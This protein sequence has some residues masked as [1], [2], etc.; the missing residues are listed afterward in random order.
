MLAPPRGA[1][2]APPSPSLPVR[3]PATI[4]V[5]TIRERAR[6]FARAAFPR[7]R[8]KLHLTRLGRDLDTLLKTTLVD[9][10]IIDI[11]TPSDEIWH[12]VDSA[13]EFPSIPF[14]A[15]TALRPTDAPGIAR[16]VAA[17]FADLLVE[18]VDDA[19]ARQMVL[20]QAYTSRFADALHEPPPSLQLNQP[21]QLSAWRVLVSYAGRVVRTDTIAAALGVTREHLSR[22]FGTGGTANLK[23]L[24][25]LVRLISA[26]ELSKNS[27]FDIGDVASILEFAS[28]SHLST[29]AQRIVGTRPASL[30]RLR[31][32]DLV[33]RFVKGRTRSRG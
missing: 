8:C 23:R 11:T 12:A 19:L 33:D 32:V 20:A 27:G 1:T 28:S 3:A 29:T 15:L 17:E 14:F 25:D 31:T 13:R 6:T 2:T 26:A 18:G 21:L 24:I 22:A 5:L 7:R 9:A 4:A 10:V 16:C 30:S